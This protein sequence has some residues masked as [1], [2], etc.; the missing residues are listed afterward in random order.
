MFKV[1]I[2][3]SKDFGDYALLEKYVDKKLS[4]VA[5]E[6][7]I[8]VV[9]SHAKRVADMAARY[10]QERGYQHRHFQPDPAKYYS[11][12]YQRAN[13][14]LIAYA[15]SFIVFWDGR[16]G[17]A[18]K[19]IRKAKEAGMRIAVKQVEAPQEAPAEPVKPWPFTLLSEAS[20]D[21]TGEVSEERLRQA[22]TT[23]RLNDRIQEVLF[24]RFCDGM[25]LQAI[26][27]SIRYYP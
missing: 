12:A 11:Q 26:G 4:R 13:E 1:V 2:A 17:A 19:L 6:D 10:A 24:Q 14:E 20:V 15:D 16:D 23:I 8:E 22:M 9:T 5:Q 27:G 18:E 21:V 25:T 7:S 3:G